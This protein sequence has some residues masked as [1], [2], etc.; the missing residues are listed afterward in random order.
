VRL[1]RRLKSF[2]ITWPTL[3]RTRRKGRT[4]T[5]DVP[6]NED[7]FLQAE[8]RER[9]AGAGAPPTQRGQMSDQSRK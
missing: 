9:C 5:H 2:A 7:K 8:L 1:V 3:F 6:A 4:V